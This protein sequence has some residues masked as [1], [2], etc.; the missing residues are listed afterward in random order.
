MNSWVEKNFLASG[1]DLSAL[2]SSTLAGSISAHLYY[3]CVETEQVN[4]S[5]IKAE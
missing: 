2:L 4:V 5:D 3:K 1:I